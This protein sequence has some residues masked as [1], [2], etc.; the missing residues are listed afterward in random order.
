MANR[1]YLVLQYDAS[2]DQSPDLHKNILF[3]KKFVGMKSDSQTV[4]M[5]QIMSDYTFDPNAHN[6]LQMDIEGVEW[7]IFE[8]LDFAILEKYFAQVI[9]EFHWCDPRSIP[10]SKRHLAILEKFQHAYQ[11]VHLR[12]SGGCVYYVKD[13]FFSDLFEV[14]YTR[15]DL[16][17]KD[18]VLRDVCGDITGLDFA[19]DIR[20]L[21]IPIDFD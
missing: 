10:R 17:P 15:K 16:L 13:R 19:D 9:V 12:Y 18:F 7:E 6:I 2:I 1:G 11:P 14:S 3:H 21:N 8:K 4:T 20:L 5:E